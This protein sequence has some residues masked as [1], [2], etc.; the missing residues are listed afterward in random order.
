MAR[1]VRRGARARPCEWLAPVFAGRSRS[2]SI[3]AGRIRGALSAPSLAAAAAARRRGADP[4]R[5]ADR[6]ARA[7]RLRGRRRPE[8]RDPRP[9]AVRPRPPSGD[10][11]RQNSAPD[12]ASVAGA[13]AGADDARPAGLLA[14][15]LRRVR[16]EMRGRYPKHPWPDRSAGAA[17]TRRAKRRTANSGTSPRLQPHKRGTPGLP[18][19]IAYSLLY[20]SES[21]TEVPHVS[22]T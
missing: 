6:L 14:R 15:Q 19:A 10:C 8:D 9:G 2:A 4:F 22:Q 21:C 5:G 11:R 20:R 17:P 1:F 12:R 3:R 16:A 7:D 13:P 18:F